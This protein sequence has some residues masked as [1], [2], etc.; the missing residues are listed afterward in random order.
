MRIQT[1]YISFKNHWII[2]SS[3]D[4]QAYHQ[5]SKRRCCFSQTAILW[6]EVLPGFS[7]TL[8]RLLSVLPGSLQVPSGLSSILPHVHKLFTITPMVLLY[9]SAEIPVTLKA[10][11]NTLLW[12]DTLLKLT[13]PSLHSKSS[14]TLLEAPCDYN[15]FCWCRVLFDGNLPTHL[16]WVGCKQATQRIPL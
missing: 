16:N 2:S 4:F 14:Q 13:L 7:P 11:W 5:H 8:P 12:S 10:S 9:Q 3:Y 15:T 1:E 6:F